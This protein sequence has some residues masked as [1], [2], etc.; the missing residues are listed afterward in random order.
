MGQYSTFAVQGRQS[1]VLSLNFWGV[2]SKK[3][4][5]VQHFYASGLQKRCTVPNLPS[6]IFLLFH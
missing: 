3:L 5:T 2:E 6:L 4:G 1:A